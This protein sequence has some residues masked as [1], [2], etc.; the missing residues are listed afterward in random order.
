[1]TSLE[2][3][4]KLNSVNEKSKI[5]EVVYAFINNFS[6]EYNKEKIRTF[7]ENISEEKFTS[8]G[9]K[10][11][12]CRIHCL[13]ELK[14]TDNEK[15]AEYLQS[16]R[17][18][19]KMLFDLSSIYQNVA[20]KKKEEKETKEVP[21]NVT[22]ALKQN[23]AVV[24]EAVTKVG[25]FRE[26]LKIAK[27]DIEKANDQIEA[28]KKTIDDKVFSLLINTVAILGIFVAIAFAGFGVTSIFS[29]INFTQACMS[30]DKLVKAVFFLITTALL[31]YNLLL[32]LV[33]FIFKLSRP[34]IIRAQKDK[35]GK[36][37]YETF[38]KTINLTPFLWI[39]GI[40]FLLSI[41]FFIWC[42]F[43]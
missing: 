28:S 9:N 17:T 43:L 14:K 6:D 42:L 10:L 34:L 30:Y 33:Y 19:E 3:I 24:N 7:I 36:E 29:N 25:Q 4:T 27:K 8:F 35:D 32:L 5:L 20:S 23:I 1:M 22:D 21:K 31:S 26:E 12:L 39:D 13:E 41:G 2:F 40:L 15:E 16:L 18:V 11:G 37:F 38:S